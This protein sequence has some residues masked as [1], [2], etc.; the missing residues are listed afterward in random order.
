MT[1]NCA[2]HL[3]LSPL[4]QVVVSKR[5]VEQTTL[6]NARRIVVVVL[7][8]GGRDAGE[9]RAILRSRANTRSE[10]RADR[11]SWSGV[12]AA[13]EQPALVLLIRAQVRR[14]DYEYRC[15]PDRWRS[16]RR[17]RAPGLL[18]IRCHIAS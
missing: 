17:R 2:L 5:K 10:V 16:C 14:V 18:P 3:Y 7:G 9:G 11:G 1:V 15:L 12:N 6:L 4:K 8:A 13:A